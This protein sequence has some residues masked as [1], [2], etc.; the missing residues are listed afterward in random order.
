ML[1]LVAALVLSVA[2]ALPAIA[3]DEV[4]TPVLWRALRA[5]G[6]EAF[7]L[8]G[9]VHLGRR[10]LWRY[11]RAI[12]DAYRRSAELVLETGADELKPEVATRLAERYGTIRAPETL[13]DRISR[14]TLD[15]LSR[16]LAT[17]R[18]SL[19]RYLQMEPW[20]IAQQIEAREAQRTG[21]DPQFGI[22]R[23]S[24]RSQRGF[25]MPSMSALCGGRP[26]SPHSTSVGAAIF[27]SRSA[28]SCSRSREPP[29][30]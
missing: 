25:Q 8:L 24:T 5:D 28:P 27:L 22:D 13:R 18:D 12:D 26:A 3:S 7:Y 29:A 4:S 23:P 30:R 19:S 1:R 17:R 21:L 14:A 16:F 11:P 10:S 9:S 6:A 2:G 15:E 20:L